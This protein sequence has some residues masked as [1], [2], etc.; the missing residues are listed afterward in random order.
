MNKPKTT[1]PKENPPTNHIAGLDGN[2]L[3]EAINRDS[4]ETPMKLRVSS[5]IHEKAQEQVN[6]SSLRFQEKATAKP[7][8]QNDSQTT[9]MEGIEASPSQ[10]Q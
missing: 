6:R 7:K 9:D 10:M 5:A 1:T 3:L 2:Q 8:T 4:G